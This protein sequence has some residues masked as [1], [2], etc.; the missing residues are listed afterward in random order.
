MRFL[1][2]EGMAKWGS[3][4]LPAPSVL[5][6]GV[7]ELSGGQ[8]SRYWKKEPRVSNSGATQGPSLAPG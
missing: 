2:A 3:G 1:S 7:L 8:Q 4:Q 5:E 6:C